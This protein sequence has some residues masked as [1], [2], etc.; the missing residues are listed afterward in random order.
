MTSPNNEPQRS[1][2]IY[3]ALKR[4]GLGFASTLVWKLGGYFL[5][6]L[7]K[8]KHFPRFISL[9]HR[10][11]LETI[12]K[13]HRIAAENLKQAIELCQ[14]PNGEKKRVLCDGHRNFREPWAHDLSFALFGLMEIGGAEAARESLEVFL[15]FQK[16]SDQF[17]IK[18]YSTGIVDRYFYSL[19]GRKQ[20]T[21]FPLQPKYY[22][23]HHTI[24][25]D[26]NALLV[27]ACFNYASYSG[28]LKF[29]RHQ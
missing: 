27:T 19:L 25:L 29:L 28:D 17:P 5:D 7:H 3:I 8:P 9:D 22:S 23:G 13:G 26:G 12:E 14:L 1:S 2:P 15:H 24:S 11:D 16:P 6:I 20:P 4:L 18:C 21:Q 10:L